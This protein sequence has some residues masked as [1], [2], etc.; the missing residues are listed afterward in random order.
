MPRKE[1]PQ[2]SNVYPTNNPERSDSVKR[3]TAST[4]SEELLSTTQPTSYRATPTFQPEA[5]SYKATPTFPQDAESYREWHRSS[6]EY[7]STVLPHKSNQ[8][9]ILSMKRKQ[10]APQ[11][12]RGVRP[13]SHDASRS[14]QGSLP[15]TPRNNS[16]SSYSSITHHRYVHKIR[17][18]NVILKIVIIICVPS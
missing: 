14:Q 6:V 13:H 3:K 5:G 18:C 11:S 8:D 9:E 4:H 17:K 16:G 10:T 15:P 1:R 7:D 2:L 12:S